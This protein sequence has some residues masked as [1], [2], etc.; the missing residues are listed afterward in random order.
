MKYGIYWSLYVVKRID[1]AIISRFDGG[2]GDPR[3]EEY[4]FHKMIPDNCLRERSC[5]RRAGVW[6]APHSSLLSG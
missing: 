4:L 3:D 6:F 2:V 1:K 5:V